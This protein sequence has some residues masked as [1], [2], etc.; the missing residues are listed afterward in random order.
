MGGEVRDR[1]R[2]GLLLGF[3]A[4]NVYDPSAIDAYIASNDA[5][6]PAGPTPPSRIRR[7]FERLDTP[8]GLYFLILAI[9]VPPYVIVYDVLDP[10]VFDPAWAAVGFTI[11]VLAIV[12]YYTE[13]GRRFERRRYES[14]RLRILTAAVLV[15]VVAALWLLGVVGVSLD[16]GART[17][18]PGGALGSVVAE[19]T[20]HGIPHLADA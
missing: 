9:A 1:T 6:N 19:L 20:R 13:T 18:I 11:G 16:V 12:P 15:V 17:L 7:F 2:C 8:L 4:Q 10:A 14:V 3:D 5:R